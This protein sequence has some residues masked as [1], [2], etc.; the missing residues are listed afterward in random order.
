MKNKKAMSK[1]L[2]LTLTATMAMGMAGC[3][4][5]E[6]ESSKNSKESENSQN[7]VSQ[8]VVESQD[9]TQEPED[10]GITY[11]LDTDVELSFWSMASLGVHDAYASWEESPHHV[12]VSDLTGID[13]DWQFVT[14]GGDETQAYNLLW[15]ADELPSMVYYNIGLTSGQ[16][17]INDGMIWD[18]T[19]YI[20][21]Y[22]P[23][24]WAYMNEPEN[25][26][27]L[28]GLY[29]GQIYCIPNMRESQYNLV[30]I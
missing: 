6:S 9:K 1:M 25:E 5:N 21:K 26:A 2:A 24:F 29:T 19:E 28:R 30:W 17:L 10:T 27:E 23:D 14:K 8:E 18:L 20:P 22:A 11:P 16:E 7:T 4:S 12:A 3:G 15:L 13:I